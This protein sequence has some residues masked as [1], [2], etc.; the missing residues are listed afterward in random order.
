MRTISSGYSLRWTSS[1]RMDSKCSG[2][3]LMRANQKRIAD[4]A[5]KSRLPS[6]YADRV[7]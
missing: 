7:L 3:P 6:M 4:F 2:G 5:I 1:A